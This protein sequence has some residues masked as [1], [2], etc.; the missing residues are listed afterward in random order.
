MSYYNWRTNVCIAN[1]SPNFKVDASQGEQ[2]LL[3]R[4]KR[5]RKVFF[6]FNI[7]FTIV[8]FLYSN[9]Y[10]FNIE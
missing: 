2:G 10:Q 4:N 6:F 5:D 9:Y 8:K 1:D 3:F 7:H